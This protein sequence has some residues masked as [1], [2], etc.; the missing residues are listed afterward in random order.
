M[1]YIINDKSNVELLP[2]LVDCISASMF[3]FCDLRAIFPYCNYNNGSSLFIN[4][5]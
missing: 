4:K 2:L 1:Y 5:S 3:K